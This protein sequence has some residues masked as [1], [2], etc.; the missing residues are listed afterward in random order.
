MPALRPRSSLLLVLFGLAVAT[1]YAAPL[2]E[3][4][5]YDSFE[6]GVP[7]SWVASRPGSLQVSDRHSKHGTHSLRWDWQAGDT[8][9]IAQTL[10]DLGRVGGYGG[11][12]SK[13]TFGLWLYCEQPVA[14][15]LVVQFR[16]GETV[17]GWFEFP[18]N[19]TGWRRAHLKYRS[20]NDFQGQVAP[21]T[22]NLRLMAPATVPAGT[23]F[24]DLVVYNGLMDYRGQYV[25]TVQPWVPTAPDPARFPLPTTIASDEVTA[26]AE[27]GRALDSMVGGSGTVTE[28]SVAALESEVARWQ[29]VPEGHGWRGLPVL[30]PSWGEF[31]AGL[32]DVLTCDKVVG[33]MLRL[34]RQYHWTADAGFRRRLAEAYALLADHLRDQGMTAGSGFGW[35]WYAG[36]DLADANFLMRQP[37]QER[38]LLQW[39]S[40]YLDYNYGSGQVFDDRTV[41]PSMDYFNNDLRPKLCGALMQTTEAERA[42]WMHAFARRLNL[43]ILNEKGDGFK[44]DG[45]AYHHGMHYFAYAGYSVNTLV[46]TVAVLSPTP[47]HLSPEALARLK[48]VVLAMRFYCNE[49][50]LPLSLSGRHPFSQAVNPGTLLTLARAA[51]RD[52]RLEPELAAAY[53]RYDPGKAETEPFKTQGLKPEPPPQGNLTMPYAG[54]TA[55]R[56]GDWLALVKG[57]GKYVTYGEIYAGNNRFGRYLSNGYLDI[58]GGGQPISRAGSG[59]VP[60][61]WDWNRLDGTTTIHLPLDKLVAVSSGTEFIGSDQTFVG[62]LSHRGRQG[63]FV[64][65]LQGGKQHD[66]SFRGRKTYFFCEDRVYCLGSDLTNTDAA[67]ET[68]TTLFQKHLADTAAPVWANGQAVTAFPCAQALPTGEVNWLL[69]PQG[70]GYV[71]PAGQNVQLAR[72]HQRSRDQANKEDNEGDFAVA[73]ISHGRAPT[74]G[75]YEY[76]LLVRTTPERLAAFAAALQT[77]QRPYEVLRQDAQAHLLRDRATGLVGCVLFAAQE[78]PPGLPLRAVDRACLVMLETEDATLHLSVADPDL[79]LVNGLSQPRPLRLTLAGDLALTE[80]V[81]DCRI[82]QAAAGQTVVEVNCREGRS[83][84][85]TLRPRR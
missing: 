34:A 20:G 50:D 79:N 24:V 23:V 85:L 47:F 13:A 57:Y 11:Y 60:Q 52:G 44:P 12:Y 26:L 21:T 37:L 3:P 1:S 39:A 64:M 83:Y 54:L 17:G 71:L 77:A 9:G 38:G 67:H 32:P 2:P 8:L 18:L 27:L 36:R 66:P 56:R 76:A 45:S 33:L 10:G 55:H 72:Q 58:L 59:C 4:A 75:R 63:L 5:L 14:D 49:R 48:R 51:G 68:E 46:N 65:Q 43:D 42:R 80:P 29:I 25:P 7:T 41:A 61:G 31:Y 53:L 70:T 73:W 81:P 82:A 35:N 62:G 74:A 30:N 6:T 84:D 69:D 15:K 78:L 19:F 22:D 28:A 16:T 40:D